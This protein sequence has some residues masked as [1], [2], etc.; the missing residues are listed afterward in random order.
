MAGRIITQKTLF[1]DKENY[2]TFLDFSFLINDFL[3][4]PINIGTPKE[5][6]SSCLFNISKFDWCDFPK[7]IPTSTI[8]LFLEWPLSTSFL[9]LLERLK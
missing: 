5:E 7:P 8:I 9:I 6:N 4:I 1:L 2:N 3:E